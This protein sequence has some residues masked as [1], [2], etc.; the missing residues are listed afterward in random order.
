MKSAFFWTFIGIGL[1]ASYWIWFREPEN[2]PY[3]TKTTTKDGQSQQDRTPQQ[4]SPRTQG[5]FP[6]TTNIGFPNVTKPR[7]VSRTWRDCP[8]EGDGGDGDLN[9]LKNRVDEGNYV[10][11]TVEQ[12]VQLPFPDEVRGKWR[13]NWSSIAKREVAKYEGTPVVVEGYLAK[14]RKQGAESPNCH[15][16]ED[17]WV[18][19]HGWLTSY[20]T[21]DRTQSVVVEPTPRIREKH[22]NWT[23][24]NMNWLVQRKKKIR[25]SGWLMLDPEH[26]DQIGKT[27]GTIWEVHPVMKMEVQENGRWINLDTYS[28]R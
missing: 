12:I 1:I 28:F 17:D 11:V 21:P 14:N 8:A 7:P 16:Y 10:P 20:P 27:R 23:S 22:P 9:R 4:T 18:D 3:P 24:N 2:T 19:Y 15:G 13:K 5:T 6:S 26:P 25:V